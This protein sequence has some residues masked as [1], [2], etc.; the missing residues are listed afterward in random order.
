MKTYSFTAFSK[1]P[2]AVPEAALKSLVVLTK[3]GKEKLLV[4][5]AG[6]FRRLTGGPR[7]KAY[8]THDLPEGIAQQLD[9]GLNAVLGKPR[10][11]RRVRSR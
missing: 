7:A 10:K 1:M 5:A 4:V 9:E 6:Y 8:F 2:R 11:A 3:R